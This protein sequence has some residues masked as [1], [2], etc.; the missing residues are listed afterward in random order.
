MKSWRY[1]I[2]TLES[3]E[4]HSFA[5]ATKFQISRQT[6]ILKWKFIYAYFTKEIRELHLPLEHSQMDTFLMLC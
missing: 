4:I 5:Y 2:G 6:D 3:K 1:G